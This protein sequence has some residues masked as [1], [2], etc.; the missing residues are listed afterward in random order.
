MFKTLKN[1]MSYINAKV[2]DTISFNI[3]KEMITHAFS[4]SYICRY[5]NLIVE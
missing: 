2:Y 5:F 1:N 4:T 3:E